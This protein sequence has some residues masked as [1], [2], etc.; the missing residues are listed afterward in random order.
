MNTTKRE[1]IWESL[2]DPDFRKQFIDEHISVGIA[3][4]IHGLRERQGLK[5]K[6][7]AERLGDEKKQPLISAWENPDYG[8]YTLGTLKDLAKAFDVGLLV[9]F[10]PFSKLVDWTIDLTHDVIAPPSFSEE[11]NY[12]VTPISAATYFAAG[13]Y[14]I[15]VSDVFSTYEGTGIVISANGTVTPTNQF[16]QDPFT[17]VPK[18]REPK[19][20]PVYA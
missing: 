20:E 1:Q 4:Q 15:N 5:Q 3:F 6:Q 11:Q 18:A 7:L 14:P 12:A 17:S 8:K 9:R 10:V 16:R 13:I 19:K 2:T